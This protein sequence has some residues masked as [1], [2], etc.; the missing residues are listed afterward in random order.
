MAHSR[1]EPYLIDLNPQEVIK[2]FTTIENFT[3][4]NPIGREKVENFKN[5]LKNK[6]FSPLEK[7]IILHYVAEYFNTDNKRSQI[8][9]YIS[10]L[11][12][13]EEIEEIEDIE[14]YDLKHSSLKYVR[15]IIDICNYSIEFYKR[16]AISQLK[17]G[18][19]TYFTEADIKLNHL[20]LMPLPFSYVP[21]RMIAFK[22]KA[23]DIFGDIFSKETITEILNNS[24][25]TQEI[26]YGQMEVL[27]IRFENSTDLNHFFLLFHKAYKAEITYICKRIDGLLRDLNESIDEMKEIHK[28]EIE[29]NIIL[30][31]KMYPEKIEQ[32]KSELYF[33][34]NSEI[35]N[36]TKCIEVYLKR[37]KELKETKSKIN[38]ARIMF[39]SFPQIRFNYL[40]LNNKKKLSVE[41]YLKIVSRNIRKKT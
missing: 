40:D 17:K 14:A 24:F 22:A 27:N 23:F 4:L 28:A 13:S 35:L 26:G 11:Q 18:K 16:K 39:M 37:I 41:D 2:V 36:Q 19:I 32:I 8:S 1:I 20:L 3:N 30:F 33:E 9:K 12:K 21:E 5:L 29:K 34:H 7:Y 15:D 38:I 31:E 10:K 6:E 25:R